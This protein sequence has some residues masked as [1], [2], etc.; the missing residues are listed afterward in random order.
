[1]PPAA[2]AAALPYFGIAGAGASLLPAIFGG[3]D[4]QRQATNSNVSGMSAAEAQEFRRIADLNQIMQDDQMNRY[5]NAQEV[6]PSTFFGAD[7][8]KYAGLSDDV[9]RSRALANLMGLTGNLGSSVTGGEASRQYLGDQAD[10]QAAG[11]AVN[12][13]VNGLLDFADQRIAKGVEQPVAAQPTPWGQSPGAG[14][15]PLTGAPMNPYE[16]PANPGASQGTGF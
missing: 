14:I 3:N 16:D 12:T 13:L 9:Q 7:A 15:N 2:A 10:T 4:Q 8:G 1:M 5:Q 6:D 11:G